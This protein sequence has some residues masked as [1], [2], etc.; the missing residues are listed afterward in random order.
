M[1]PSASLVALMECEDAVVCVLRHLSTRD[2]VRCMRV[3]TMFSRILRNLPDAWGP[4]VTLD[5]HMPLRF[6]SN[7]PWQMCTKVIAPRCASRDVMGTAGMQLRDVTA[8]KL[9]VLEWYQFMPFTCTAW[10]RQLKR[11]DMSSAHMVPLR[12][13]ALETP[14]LEWLRV[15]HLVDASGLQWVAT[16]RN[17]KTLVSNDVSS[18]VIGLEPAELFSDPP[19]ERNQ[20]IDLVIDIPSDHVLR[21]YMREE[22]T[23]RFVAAS[24]TD[25]M[26]AL[27]RAIQP[28]SIIYPIARTNLYPEHP[29]DEV[30]NYL[31]QLPLYAPVGAL[32]LGAIDLQLNFFVL[33]FIAR[34]PN[35]RV[36]E[37]FPSNSFTMA[38]LRR[39]FALPRLLELDMS[40]NFLVCRGRCLPYGWWHTFIEEPRAI[41]TLV[42]S[43]AAT[44]PHRPDEMC[45][46][47]D[48]GE[49]ESLF[50][51]GSGL[52]EIRKTGVDVQCISATQAS[53]RHRVREQEQCYL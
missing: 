10:W 8:L 16:M 9:S 43:A 27:V 4:T 31:P 24:G 23:E 45:T 34:L 17:L 19:P 20:N 42:I 5:E 15:P 49:E 40:C 32:Y 11:L 50:V 21:Q 2:A 38:N 35:L 51:C 29:F 30:S 26:A 14:D 33:D 48:T 46:C 18:V 52:D 41:K 6:I 25:S 37:L 12:C 53:R 7:M 13:V 39:I 44:R 47:P 22:E 36:L 1:P 3:C 28:K